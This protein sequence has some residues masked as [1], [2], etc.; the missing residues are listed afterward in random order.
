M[1]LLDDKPCVH[2]QPC[3]RHS[4][5]EL[6]DVL[7]CLCVCKQCATILCENTMQH[8][9]TASI[10]NS[11]FSIA[12][13][14]G[15]TH[16]LQHDITH[17]YLPG[18]TPCH[19]DVGMLRTSDFQ[20]LAVPVSRTCVVLVVAKTAR[21]CKLPRSHTTVC[22]FPPGHLALQKLGLL[23]TRGLLRGLV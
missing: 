23:A 22:L 10:K 19:L 16:I 6:T 21:T 17:S 15:T 2:Y 18:C 3:Y 11:H 7:Q 14:H 13:A 20:K 4:R 5:L 12:L 1:S 9:I 8:N